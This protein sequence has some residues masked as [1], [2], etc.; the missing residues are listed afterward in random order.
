MAG[1]AIGESFIYH[2]KITLQFYSV[3]IGVIEIS[4]FLSLM[5]LDEPLQNKKL[6]GTRLIRTTM[7]HAIRVRIVRLS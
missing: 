2:T 4:L 1:E 7:G 5:A 6:S 3:V